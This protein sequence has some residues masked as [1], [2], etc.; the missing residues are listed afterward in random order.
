MKKVF[1]NP[2]LILGGCLFCFE[3]LVSY[4]PVSTIALWIQQGI[5]FVFIFFLFRMFFLFKIPLFIKKI[6]EKVPVLGVILALLGG[7]VYWKLGRKI[8]YTLRNSM[9][10]L[11]VSPVD[12]QTILDAMLSIFK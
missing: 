5:L 11:E 4:L 8:Y 3:K 10:N 6:R 1:T 2:F 9:G 7:Y 12:E